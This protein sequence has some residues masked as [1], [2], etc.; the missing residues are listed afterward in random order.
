MSIKI[1]YMCLFRKN[2]MI[3]D[4][5]KLNNM[6]QKVGTFALWYIFIYQRW[7]ILLVIKAYIACNNITE[8]QIKTRIFLEK[9]LVLYWKL[10]NTEPVSLGASSPVSFVKKM[11]YT[12]NF[13]SK[14][15]LLLYDMNLYFNLEN[16]CR[17]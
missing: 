8:T 4:V 12:I 1:C 5:Q 14:T 2:L 9:T 6:G 17:M 13:N 11:L 3:H 15:D 16:I 7:F 10:I